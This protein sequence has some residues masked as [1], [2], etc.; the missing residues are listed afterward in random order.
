[1]TSKTTDMKN[2]SQLHVSNISAKPSE[3]LEARVKDPLWF[4]ARQWQTGEFEAENGGRPALM[5]YT[6]RDHA[7]TSVQLGTGPA[8]ILNGAI[9]LEALVEAESASLD[10]AAWRSTELEYEFRLK[11]KGHDLKAEEYSG[12]ALDWMHFDH[13]S[14]APAAAPTAATRRMTPTQLTFPGAPHPR[15]WRLEEG[16]AYF[17]SPEDPEPN[18]LSLLLPELFYTDIENWYLVP[19]PVSAGNLRE[20]T[21]VVMV[22]S[23]G[24]TTTLGPAADL[25]G[26][27]DWALFGIDGAHEPGGQALDGQFLL[28]P[29]IAIEVVENDEIEEVRFLRDE[30]ANLVWAWERK[31]EGSMTDPEKQG[32]LP[33]SDNPERQLFLLMSE[34]AREWIPYVPR[35]SAA[36]GA[37]DGQTFLRRARSHEQYSSAVPQFRSRI[38][39][40][41]KQIAEEVIPPQGLRVRRV[42]RYARGS[43]G[44]PYF[45]VGREKETST[46]TAR[47]GLRFDFLTGRG[48]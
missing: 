3:A 8:K 27:G 12:K 46:R 2:A 36:V 13:T 23:F 16:E 18:V 44:A 30:N 19:M 21:Q 14:T 41:A 26:K 7:F 6:A 38:I 47:P 35:Q 15:W 37:G 1:L 24:H 5:S 22:D 43:D 42:N 25:H 45:W 17:D 48:A 20:V 10:A 29:N 33:K 11:A 9:P 31:L 4:L 40:E 34:T 39:S 28:V 32:P